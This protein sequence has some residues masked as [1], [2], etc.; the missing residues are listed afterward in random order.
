MNSTNAENVETYQLYSNPM[1]KGEKPNDAKDDDAVTTSEPTAN[2]GVAMK[3]N[4]SNDQ[5]GVTIKPETDNNK[6]NIC[7][8]T[9]ICNCFSGK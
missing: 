9:I 6:V 4:L 5:V 3:D 1:T 2:K 8:F 7:S